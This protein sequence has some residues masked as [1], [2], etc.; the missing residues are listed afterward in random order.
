M[1]LPT[2]RIRILV[3]ALIL[4][5]LV[6]G[7]NVVSMQAGGCED[8]FLRCLYDPFNLVNQISGGVYCLSGYIFCKK[9]I[10]PSQ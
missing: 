9:Y 4:I 8:A 7:M 10:E 6:F 2:K 3:A 5:C 1:L